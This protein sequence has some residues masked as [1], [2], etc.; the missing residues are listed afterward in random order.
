MDSKQFLEAASNI[1]NSNKLWQEGFHK[2]IFFA[3]GDK[4]WLVRGNTWTPSL[5]LEVKPHNF[6]VIDGGIPYYVASVDELKPI[7]A[8][9]NKKA[10][11]VKRYDVPGYSGYYYEVEEEEN[12]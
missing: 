4:V 11:K 5:V 3:S 2:S 8:I 10:V 12:E 9:G 1:E 6:Y 7:E